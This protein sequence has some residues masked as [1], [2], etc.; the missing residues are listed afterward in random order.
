MTIRDPMDWIELSGPTPG[1]D[2]SISEVLRVLR[3]QDRDLGNQS[4]GIDPPMNA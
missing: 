2:P 1:L 4:Q 3:G